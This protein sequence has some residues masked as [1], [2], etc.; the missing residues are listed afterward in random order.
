MILYVVPLASVGVQH[1]VHSPSCEVHVVLRG[2][3]PFFS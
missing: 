3:S 1:E 2:Q